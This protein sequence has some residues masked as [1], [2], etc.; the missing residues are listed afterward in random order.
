MD[1]KNANRI[2]V[3]LSMHEAIQ[4]KY[5]HRYRGPCLQQ[6]LRSQFFETLF[7]AENTYSST[8]RNMV[9]V[10]SEEDVLRIQALAA[11]CKHTVNATPKWSINCDGKDIINEEQ[12]ATNK[13]EDQQFLEQATEDLEADGFTVHLTDR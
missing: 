5:W 9:Y 1:S 6:I 8:K 11:K 7:I 2:E 10:L 13:P 3:I 12:W 4:A